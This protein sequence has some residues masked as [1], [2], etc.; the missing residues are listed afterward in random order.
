[1]ALSAAGYKS[2]IYSGLVSGSKEVFSRGVEEAIRKSG[3]T[4]IAVGE[5]SGVEPTFSPFPKILK[6]GAVI[7]YIAKFRLDAV[8]WD[9]I[10]HRA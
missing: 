6:P 8:T 10:I 9:E 7:F 3:A 1:M 4:L 2:T 5:S